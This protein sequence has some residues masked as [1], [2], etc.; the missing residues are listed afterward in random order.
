MTL[1]QSEV[2]MVPCA[3]CSRPVR[4]PAGKAKLHRRLR[5]AMPYTQFCSARCA[6]EYVGKKGAQQQEELARDLA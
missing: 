2:V 1:G 3:C 6:G 5:P 4:V